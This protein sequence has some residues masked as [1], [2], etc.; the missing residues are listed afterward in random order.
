M[1]EPGGEAMTYVRLY[2]GPD[3]ESRFEGVEVTLGPVEFIPGRPVVELSSPSP[4]VGAAF[5]RLPAGWD[6]GERYNGPRRSFFVTLAGEVEMALPGDDREGFDAT[7]VPQGYL[8]DPPTGAAYV[9]VATVPRMAINLFGREAVTGGQGSWIGGEDIDDDAGT[10]PIPIHAFDLVIAD[11]CH[12]GYT[13][14]E[15]SVRRGWAAP[16]HPAAGPVIRGRSIRK[17]GCGRRRTRPVQ[18]DG[19]AIGATPMTCGIVPAALRVIVGSAEE[20][21]GCAWS[22]PV[23]V[24]P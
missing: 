10:L 24:A 14:K 12:R 5:I 8:L 13:S 20:G 16:E 17:A 21:A 4:A 23:S 15:L 22:P 19:T 11:E 7:A 2:A 18:A 1:I 6:S 3:G 9:Y